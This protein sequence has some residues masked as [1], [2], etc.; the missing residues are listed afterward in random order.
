MSTSIQALKE[1]RANVWSQMQ[2]VMA[3]A[4]REG[5]PLTAE[6]RQKWDAAEA[7]LDSIGDTVD[8]LERQAAR[9]AAFE[10]VDRSELVGAG[11]G[12]EPDNR[13]GDAGKPDPQ[14][15]YARAFAGYL[16]SGMGDLADDEKRELLKGHVDLRAAGVGSGAAGGYTVPAPFRA[17]MIEAIKTYGGM[18]Q[19]AE[20][21]TTDTGATLPWP[22][23]DDTANVGAILAENTQMSEQDVTIGTNNIDAYMYT[24]KLVRVSYQLL[25]DSAFDLESWLQRKL[26]E[27]I[28]RILNQHF[29]TG[30]GTNQPDGLATSAVVGKQGTTGQTTSVIYDDLI[31][32]IDSIDPAYQGNAKFMMSQTARKSVR[33]L[34]DTTGQP[35]WQPS[36]LAGVPDVLLGYPYVLNQDMPSPAASAK[37]ILFGDFREAYLIRLVTDLNVMRLNERFADF[38]QVAFAAYERADGTLQNSAAVRAYQNSAT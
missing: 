31:D 21:I 2:E 34:K 36:V 37:S 1:R 3:V 27:R 19:E 11:T 28:G 5:R 4:E 18:L 13:G 20:V 24:S 12:A 17:K 9:A 8:R 7:D 32:L 16:R 29:T 23:N 6:E 22:T 25:Q 35:L 14:E 33:K 38:L 10:K 26:G 30:T 15:T